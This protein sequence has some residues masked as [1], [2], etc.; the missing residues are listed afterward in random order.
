MQVQ[1]INIT[2]P[3]TVLKALQADVPAGKRSKFIAK[4]LS[5]KL[6]K[7]ATSQKELERSLKANSEFYK[8]EAKVWKVTET[9]NWPD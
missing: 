4:A 2:L 5:E 3:K 7:R 9:E 1:R 6:R 8:K